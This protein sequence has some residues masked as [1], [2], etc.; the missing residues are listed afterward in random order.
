MAQTNAAQS[1]TMKAVVWEGKPYEVA[2]KEDIPFP[3]LEA[4]EDAIVR[5]TTSA[6]CGTDLHNYR[7]Y[8]GSSEVPYL[9]GHEAMGIV[10]EVGDAVDS[11]RVGDRVLILLN[12]QDGLLE[13]NLAF[14]PTYGLG[15]DLSGDLGGL[16]GKH[17]PLPLLTPNF[18]TYSS[19]LKIP[20]KLPDKEWLFLGDIFPTAW[21]GLTWS[22]F[23]AGDT[24]AIFGAGPVG[25]LCAYSAMI[26]GASLVYVI[27]YVPQRLAKAA[28][29]GAV[30]IN[31]AKGGSASEQILALQP[32]GVNRCVDCCGQEGSLNA[33]LKPQQDYILR[34]AIAVTSFRGGIGVPGLYF[35]LPKSP[36][37][38]NADKMQKELSVPISDAWLKS[39]T[40][41]FGNVELLRTLPALF[42]LIDN[43]RARPGFVVTAEFD[44]DEAPKAYTLF[45]K[46]LEIKTLFRGPGKEGRDDFVW[47]AHENG[48]NGR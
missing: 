43:G 26:R 19:L 7:G 41:K 21:E 23:E 38:P 37:T 30:P 18:L 13:I 4:P 22:G 47:E 8:L 16:Q 10:E 36:G 5:I 27:D 15:K 34:E 2:V 14:R 44:L 28:E 12:P 20:K 32:N 17:L 25:L 24:V 48:T 11:F 33:E 40:I 1:K 42:K 31:F 39:I 46:Q 35:T 6:I 3:R 29:I 9:L 45:N